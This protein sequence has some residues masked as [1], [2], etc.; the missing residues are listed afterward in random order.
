M[1]RHRA[2]TPRESPPSK[3]ANG[4]PDD[5]VCVVEPS[6]AARRMLWHVFALFYWADDRPDCHPATNEPGEIK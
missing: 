3:G 1:A 2:S 5:R 4:R 6:V